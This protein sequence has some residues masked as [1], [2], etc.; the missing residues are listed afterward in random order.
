MQ[1]L[2]QKTNLTTFK[3]IWFAL[4]TSNF[5]YGFCLYFTILKN[6]D[7][8]QEVNPLLT[9]VFGGMALVLL[10]LSFFLPKFILNEAKKNMAGKQA[11]VDIRNMDIESLMIHFQTFF[12][13]RLAL[14]ES[15]ALFGFSLGFLNKNMELFYPFVAVTMIGF[16]LNFPNE[17]KIRNAFN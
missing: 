9:P 8:N 14:L 7:Q 5:L 12:I 16:L 2:N 10:G 17:E 15:V 3:A 4:F 13:L 11:H 6:P 1:Q